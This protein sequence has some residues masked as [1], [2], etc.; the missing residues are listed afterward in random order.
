MLISLVYVFECRSRSI[1]E[2]RLKFESNSTRIIYYV[3]IY[4]LPSLCLLVYFIVPTDQEAAKLDALRSFPCPTKEFFLE[5]TF[6][7]LSDPFWL[8]FIML[9][10][11]PA[12]TILIFGNIFFHVSC[13][14]FYLYMA[15]G[16]MTSI[17]T[18]LIQRRFFIGMF[19]QTGFP[20]IVLAIPYSVLG[21]SIAIGR[22]S[23][24]ITNISFINFGVHGLVESICI[25]TFHHS[26]RLY[27]QKWFMKTA[28]I[29]N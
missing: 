19:A 20:F 4:T 29:K 17:R 15:P 8:S 14:I 9:F 3:I 23:Q 13:C 27:I 22:V 11:I 21:V 7:V 25:I 6:V 24:V 26:Y 5:Q 16:A 2:N 28:I 10:A 1:Q 18:R 12:I